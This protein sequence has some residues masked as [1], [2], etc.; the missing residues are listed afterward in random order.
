[1]RPSPFSLMSA[2]L[3]QVRARHPILCETFLWALPAVLFGAFLRLCFLR[4]M[5]YAY[6]GADSRSYYDFTFKLVT[7]HG[8]SLNE[9]R[10][11]LYPLYAALVTML[12][13]TPLH[14]FA[15]LQHGFGLLT[16]FPLAYTVRKSFT[17]WKGW[18]IPVTVLYA[19]FPIVLWYEHELLGET[20]FFAFIVWA[21]A[22]WCAWM[23]ESARARAGRL[24]WWFLVP[25]SIF[26][27]T[28]PSGR[29]Y[30]PGLL[31]GMLI[32]AAWRRFRWPQY[33]SIFA[34]MIATLLIGSMKL[35][36]WLLYSATFP[37]TQLQTPL[38]AEYK[39]QIRDMVEP[40]RK[41]LDVYYAHDGEPFEFL[42]K[43]D[44]SPER[45]LWVPLKED[46][47]LR[48]KIYL[49]L[50]KEGIKAEPLNFLYL[51]VQRA[52]ASSNL[53][54]FK[55]HRFDATFMANRFHDDY[56]GAQRELAEGKGSAEA[57]VLGFG[58]HGPLPPY[59][60]VQPRLSPAPDS[61]AAH[62]VRDW[63]A[64]WGN[65]ID[66]VIL[67]RWG[68]I[69]EA[70]PIWRLRPTFAGCWLLLA[71]A[72]SLLPAYRPTIGVWSL[73]AYGYIFGV[74]MVTQ[75]NP[76]YFGAAWPVFIPLL[77]VPLDSLCRFL[78]VRQKAVAQV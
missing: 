76:R 33:A 64:G 18:I 26:I 78:F 66:L 17:F 45:T 77:A 57:L 58:A 11:L 44:K 62:V 55:L 70:E 35:G 1:M 4:Y 65:K 61:F 9:K 53:S 41:N 40:L 8:F 12:P 56:D 5:P 21:C 52:I 50:A 24:W 10:R 36:A 42:D 31:L 6:W 47:K 22:G 63:V 2:F 32:V 46:Y 68:A 20:F 14:W 30:W 48:T 69:R 28:K 7:T 72:L 3:S 29:F 25:F 34:L 27:L 71:F 37:L 60:E 59:E 67:P 51:G 39:A 74:F 43:P 38:H 54:A 73:A 19:G 15:W 16:L 23:G 49:D 13:G 75:I